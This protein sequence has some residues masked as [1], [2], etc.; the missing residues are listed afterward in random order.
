MTSVLTF[1]RLRAGNE[2]AFLKGCHGNWFRHKDHF[3]VWVVLAC[4]APQA[5]PV[6]CVKLSRIPKLVKYYF[7]R[8]TR[9]SHWTFLSEAK[10]KRT[11][12][13]PRFREK[14]SDCFKVLHSQ[15]KMYCLWRQMTFWKLHFWALKKAHQRTFFLPCA[16]WFTSDRALSSL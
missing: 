11:T 3:C 1:K 10:K 8:P 7:N 5:A 15:L 13:L 9:P 16:K 2:S 14:L 6:R 12:P 4:S